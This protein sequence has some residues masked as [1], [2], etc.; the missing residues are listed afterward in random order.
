[1]VDKLLLQ[2]QLQIA[3]GKIKLLPE[4]DTP[5]TFA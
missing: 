1:M 3:K 2:L 5:H 4:G